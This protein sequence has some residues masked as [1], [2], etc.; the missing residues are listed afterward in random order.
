M[1][2]T[3]TARCYFDRASAPERLSVE[4]AEEQAAMLQDLVMLKQTAVDYLHPERPVVTTDPTATARCYFDRASAPQP[5]HPEEAEERL[6]ILAEAQQLKDYARMYHHPED[7]VKTTDATATARCYF[8]R[9]SAP[10]PEDVETAAAHLR[11]LADARALKQL[12]VDYMHPERPVVTTDPYACG[13]NYFTRPS[14]AVVEEDEAERAQILREAAQLKQLAVDYMHPEAPVVTTDPYAMG[15]NYFTRP[16]APVVDEDEEERARILAECQALKQAAVDYHH[17]ELPV[18]TTDPL[19]CG[20]NYFTRPSAPMVDQDDEAERAAILADC[21][22]LK[23][24]AVD[25]LHPENPVV[26]TDPTAC[27]RNYFSRFSAPQ[28][29]P[30]EQEERAQI[31]ADCAA[32]KQKA[33]DYLHPEIPVVTTDPTACGRNY[34]SRPSAPEQMDPAEAEECARILEEAKLLKELAVHYHHPEIGVVTKDPT[35]TGRNYFSRYSARGHETMVHTFPAHDDHHEEHHE[36]VE[37]W[38]MDEDAMFEDMRQQIHQ[39]IPTQ[40]KVAAGGEEE[41]SNLSRSPSSVML[42]LGESIYD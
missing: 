41:E 35:A 26:T 20:R 33:V 24:N 14:A 42:H 19:A 39:V 22:A 37:H 28:V 9:Y 5:E 3:A 18:V 10:Q 25:Y 31:L 1:D 23:Q 11:V 2:S 4:E 27:G 34:Y 6:A 17:P 29:D 21:Q 16:S 7:P 8:D 36:H 40:G 13:R 15:R 38:G 12:A 30:A 32:L